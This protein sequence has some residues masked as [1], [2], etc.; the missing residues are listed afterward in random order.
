[1]SRRDGLTDDEGVVMDALCDAANA[2]GRLLRQHP[3]EPRDFRD[4]IHRCQDLLALRIAR[5]HHPDGW[6]VKVVCNCGAP[7]IASG[8][9]NAGHAPSDTGVNLPS[10][11]ERP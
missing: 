6:P 1:M 4:A 8:W 2:Y 9:C 5:R 11:R 3:D 10:S 7:I